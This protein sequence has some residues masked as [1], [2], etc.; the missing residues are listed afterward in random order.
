MTTMVIV[1]IWHGANYT[2]LLFGIMHAFY[3]IINHYWI[4]YNKLKKINIPDFI[5]WT[6]TYLSVLIAQI[7]FRAENI[8]DALIIYKGL[9]SFKWDVYS[10][11][12]KI[13]IEFIRFGLWGLEWGQPSMLEFIKLL[14]LSILIIKYLPSTQNILNATCKENL[15]QVACT[16]SSIVKL[17]LDSFYFIIILLIIYTLS[18]RNLGENSEFLYF[19]F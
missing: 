7:M 6:I 1:G 14:L 16:S 12:D 5:C 2:F 15:N 10:Q 3:L 8:H 18:I 9:L 19:Q 4:N 17:R 13:D 11:I